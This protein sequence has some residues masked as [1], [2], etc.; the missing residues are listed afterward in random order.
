M[1]SHHCEVVAS[2]A[3]ALSATSS[4]DERI[5]CILFQNFFLHVCV[6]GRHQAD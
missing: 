5:Y 2:A 4:S 3:V 6:L 1:R